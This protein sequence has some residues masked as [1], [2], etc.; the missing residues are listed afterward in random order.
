[1]VDLNRFLR[2]KL[3]F[4]GNEDRVFQLMATA[5]CNVFGGIIQQLP[6]VPAD[7]NPTL[8]VPLLSVLPHPA[9][10]VDSI[11]GTLTSQSL[12]N[13]GL[14]VE[15]QDRVYENICRASNIVP[16]EDTKR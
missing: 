16:Y 12:V 15:F 3:H 1:Q 11:I 9:D 6:S 5:L 4:L 2:A 14:F 8:T 7:D 10:T 13:A